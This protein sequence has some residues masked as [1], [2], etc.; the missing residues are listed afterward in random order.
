[1]S[2]AVVRSVDAQRWNNAVSFLHPVLDEEYRG[3]LGRLPGVQIEGFVRSQAIL[4][5]ANDTIAVSMLGLI[6]AGSLHAVN[7][8]SGRMAQTDNEIV[9]G[10]DLA[11]RLGVATGSELDLT[12]RNDRRRVA[13]VGVKSDVVLSEAIMSLPALQ[14]LLEMEEQATGMFVAGSESTAATT[15]ADHLR[16]LAFVGR[17]TGRMA[18]VGEFTA[19]LE[20]IRRIVL[21]V[22]GIALFVAVVF[23]AANLSMA[24]AEQATEFSTLWALG[25]NRSAATRIVLVNALVQTALGLLLAV[26][27]TAVLAALL[28][29]LAS[30]AWF[31]QATYVSPLIPLLVGGS[32]VVLTV[33]GTHLTFRRFWQSDLLDNLR[34]RSIQ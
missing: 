15:V 12:I 8:V 6:P 9:L 4:E 31:D 3:S 34:T 27:L 14:R 32:V 20:D 22:A 11:R 19:F 28:N 18:L 1:M 29:A 24:V 5:N 7:L 17:V 26:P 21:L 33:V 10:A 30:R 25:F 2:Q 16:A 13:V 23:I